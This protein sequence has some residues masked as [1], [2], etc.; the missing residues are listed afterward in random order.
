MAYKIKK[1]K[2]LPR[3]KKEDIFPKKEKGLKAKVSRAVTKVKL[4][5]VRRLAK[6]GK[7]GPAQPKAVKPSKRKA[8]K[9]Q[10]A[11]EKALKGMGPNVGIGVSGEKQK[12][13]KRAAVS[14]SRAGKKRAKAVKRIKKLQ[15]AGM[16]VTR[17]KKVP[18]KET[19]PTGRIRKGAKKV[20]VTKGGAYA[21]YEKGSKA[22][23]SFRKAFK[24]GCAGGAKSFSWD[25]R[26]YSCKKK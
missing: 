3:R 13:R 4:A 16:K 24:S 20:L 9:G 15:K 21:S 25:G 17:V 12:K 10:K 18:L 14:V 5:G 6:K 7:F 2:A 11:A 22:A 8:R 23:G 1:K 19:S 26:S